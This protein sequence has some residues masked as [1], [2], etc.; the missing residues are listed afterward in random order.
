MPDPDPGYEGSATSC[1]IRIHK[2]FHRSIAGSKSKSK[3]VKTKNKFAKF[4]KMGKIFKYYFSK[5]TLQCSNFFKL[6]TR[7]TQVILNLFQCFTN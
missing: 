4:H 3:N 1:L 5:D 6:S 2:L 7:D